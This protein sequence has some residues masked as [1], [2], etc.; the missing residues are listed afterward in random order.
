MPLFYLISIIV[1]VAIF[2][3]FTCYL[4]SGRNSVSDQLF[5][6]GIQAE[7]N[8][9]YEQ[10]ATSYEKALSELKNNRFHRRLE[11]QIKE[12]LKLLHDVTTY[13]RDQNF[14]RENN[15]WIK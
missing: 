14:I 7:N 12:K 4:L 10:A 1:L 3:V 2:I 13:E 15:S 6:K 5:I 9:H 8:G 11:L